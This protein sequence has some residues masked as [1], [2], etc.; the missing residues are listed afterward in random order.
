MFYLPAWLLIT[1]LKDLQQA[2][3]SSGPDG[4]CSTLEPPSTPCGGS[5]RNPSDCPDRDV[6]DNC[7]PTFPPWELFTPPLIENTHH[8]T[9]SLIS[10][11]ASHRNRNASLRLDIIHSATNWKPTEY[12]T[13]REKK[14]FLHLTKLLP[15][16]LS[17]M[18]VCGHFAFTG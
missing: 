14:I 11:V 6:E 9:N 3:Q 8:R 16:L 7:C 1:L 5:M 15:A 10:L 4:R 18:C 2:C 17:H 13:F 12:Q